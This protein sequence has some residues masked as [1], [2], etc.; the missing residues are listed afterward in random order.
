MGITLS[1]DGKK[2]YVTTGRGG[3]VLAIDT[4]TDTVTATVQN[5]GP[6]PWGIAITP[7][8]QTLYT[9]NGPSN[10]VTAIDTKT[11]T[12]KTRIPVGASP[13]GIATSH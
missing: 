13:W 3:T 8:G 11:L 6:R 9:A 10:D 12:I 5:V 1:P 7:D 2:A 4:A